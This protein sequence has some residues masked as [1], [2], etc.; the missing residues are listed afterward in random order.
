MAYADYKLCDLCGEKAF[1]D[2]CVTDP[3]YEATWDPSADCDPIG[4]KVLCT[5]CAKTH[6]VVVVKKGGGVWQLIET[7]PNAGPV[8]L[9]DGVN[10]G[11]GEWRTARPSTY[12]IR[13]EVGWY[14]V[15]DEPYARPCQPTHWMP[16]PEPPKESK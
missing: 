7:V 9:S 3:R 10:V 8:L 15:G 16:L 11:E 14:F 5:E 2:T 12:G 1:Y 6:D 4:I 13:G